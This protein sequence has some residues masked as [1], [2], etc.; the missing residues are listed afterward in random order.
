LFSKKYSIINEIGLDRANHKIPI[1]LMLTQRIGIL[2]IN[3]YLTNDGEPRILYDKFETS[4][5][6]KE[7]KG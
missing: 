3:E 4:E 6:G 7:Y 5:D 2:D 1:T